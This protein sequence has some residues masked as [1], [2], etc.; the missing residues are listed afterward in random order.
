VLELGFPLNLGLRLAPGIGPYL[1][2]SIPWWRY[3][4]GN[5]LPTT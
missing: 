3:A 4:A 5:A 1:C 2:P